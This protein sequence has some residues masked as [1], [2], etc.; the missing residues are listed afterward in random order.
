MC[1]TTWCTTN[2]PEWP[3]PG[4]R[5][6]D[7]TARRDPWRF[8]WAPCQDKPRTGGRATQELTVHRKRHGEICSFFA[9]IA[10][11]IWF[12][13]NLY[14]FIW[15]CM[16]VTM[17]TC[18]YVY[19]CIMTTS[20]IAPISLLQLPM[21]YPLKFPW[22]LR[23]ILG[24]PFHLCRPQEITNTVTPIKISWPPQISRHNRM[25]SI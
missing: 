6:I 5:N 22:S 21:T 9:R 17:C 12:Y 2:V 11:I 14:E 4:G 13:M 23:E 20:Y 3:K 25:K 19:M 15:F 24:P 8:G 1:G 10:L 16:Y 18:G 7:S